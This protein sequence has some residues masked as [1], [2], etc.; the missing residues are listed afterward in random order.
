MY[1]YINKKGQTVVQPQFH[2]AHP[3]SGGLARVIVKTT[4]IGE[5]TVSKE[6]AYVTKEG[7][8][9]STWKTGPPRRPSW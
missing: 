9:V 5:D 2:F 3:F 7:K 1:G 8:V 4:L 6:F